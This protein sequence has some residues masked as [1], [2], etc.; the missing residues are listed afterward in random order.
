M[1]EEDLNVTD[2]VKSLKAGNSNEVKCHCKVFRPWGWY[3]NIEGHD[4]NG[5]KVK[6]I[7]VYPGK[8]LSLQSHM[9]RSEHWVIVKGN[10]KVQVGKDFLN[11]ESNHHVNIPKETLHR[12][13]N[14]GD[15]LL[16]FV[17]TQIGDYLGEDD[18]V[19]YEDDFGRV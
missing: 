3:V 1:K 14:V 8:R 19:R 16:E 4:T 2:V 18:I 5:F 10:A 11:L 7:G 6:R 9:S 17:E 13:E 15:I 12:M